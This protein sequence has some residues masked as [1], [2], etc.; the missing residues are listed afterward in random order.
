MARLADRMCLCFTQTRKIR[1]PHCQC[2]RPAIASI[3]DLTRHTFSLPATLFI[4]YGVAH[5][6][7]SLNG[8]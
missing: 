1:F 7:H 2:R 3:A 6:S 4:G 5:E 8:V